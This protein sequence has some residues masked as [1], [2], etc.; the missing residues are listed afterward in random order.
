MSESESGRGGKMARSA[1]LPP[2]ETIYSYVSVNGSVPFAVPASIFS[3]F[4][5]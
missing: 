2:V 1:I 5:T 4:A 3:P